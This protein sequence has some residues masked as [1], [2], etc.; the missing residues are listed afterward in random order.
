VAELWDAYDNNYQKLENVTLVRGEPIPYGYLHLVCSIIVK[1]TDGSY[2]LMQRDYRK[3]HGGKWELSANG[4]VL[5]GETAMQGAV[6]ELH[7]ETG[8]SC[9]NLKE[10]KYLV[11]ENFRA[12]FVYFFCETNQPKDSIVLQKGETINYKWVTKE[13]LKSI[14]RDELLSQNELEMV[15]QSGL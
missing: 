14:N 9:N 12:I 5:K 6:R 7:E 1:H 10:L 11:Q 3:H 15:E 4:S 2:L 8:I 13:E